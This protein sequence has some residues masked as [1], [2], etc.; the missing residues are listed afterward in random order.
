MKYI[1]SVAL[2]HD[3]VICLINGLQQFLEATRPPAK[4]RGSK[5]AAAAS[6][7]DLPPSYLQKIHHFV[8]GSWQHGYGQP[9]T[10]VRKVYVPYN[11]QGCHWVALEID[12][13]RHTV[14]V[15][16]SY[17]AFTSNAKLGKYLEPISHILAHVLY[18]MRFYEASEVEEVKQHG[19]K[20]SKFK[21]LTICS[22]GD[23][24]QQSDG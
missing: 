8:Y 17:I 9:W 5:K 14:T 16:D 11:L 15:Y 19:M 2:V 7:V 24:P 3:D 20:M 18:D 1:A 10:K 12:F 6:T 22:I 4:K 13:V 23:V 21:P